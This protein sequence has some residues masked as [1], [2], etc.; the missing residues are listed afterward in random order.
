MARDPLRFRLGIN[1]IIFLAVLI[2]GTLIFTSVEGWSFLNAF[3]Y[4]I[5]TIA[6][7]GYGD[8]LPSTST[9]KIFAILLI[10]IGVGTFL[11]VIA[12]TTEIILTRREKGIR[13]KKLN[14]LIGVFFSE[15]G[16]HLIR[17]FVASDPHAEEIRRDLKITDRWTS[18]DFQNIKSSL[19]QFCYSVEIS[20]THLQS[21]K[22]LLTS[23]RDFFA[24]L[25]E[26]PVLMEHESFTDLLQAT[27]HLT[28]ELA[29]R[30]DLGQLP[31]SDL[32]HLKGDEI[33]VYQ[34][35]VQEWVVYMEYLKG[36]YPYLFSLAMRI[37][38]FIPQASPV[39]E[40]E[41]SISSPEG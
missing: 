11:G 18:R 30:E 26:N 22:G 9:G 17:L 13:L 16:N 15:V 29:Y 35:L 39:V 28:E 1:L 14:M 6:T 8:I 40:K 27:F 37:N 3:Y 24:R 10:I 31:E 2:S 32:N 41:S 38:P 33:R 36:N 19:K 7:V 12:N 34:L 4:V 21:L 23:Q 5:V 20:K 25:L